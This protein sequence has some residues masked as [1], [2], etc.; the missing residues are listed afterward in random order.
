VI[1]IVVE[2]GGFGRLF[3]EIPDLPSSYRAIIRPV[4]P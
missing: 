1:V 2:L 4:L 3:H